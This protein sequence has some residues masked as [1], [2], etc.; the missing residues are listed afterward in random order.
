MYKGIR[1]PKNLQFPACRAPSNVL[2]T[3]TK[4]KITS[5]QKEKESAGQMME[6]KEETRQT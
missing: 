1:R 3:K 2:E 4:I 5:E 6:E